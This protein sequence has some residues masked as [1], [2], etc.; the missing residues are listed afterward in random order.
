MLKIKQVIV[1]FGRL[2][3]LTI[4][5]AAAGTY[6][7]SP[8][9]IKL[10]AHNLMSLLVAMEKVHGAGRQSSNWQVSSASLVIHLKLP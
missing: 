8:Q 6:S 1:C 4:M 9:V 2:K 3:A 7:C 10:K 5:A